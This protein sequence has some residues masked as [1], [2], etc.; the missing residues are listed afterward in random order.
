MLDN[1][2]VYSFNWMRVDESPFQLEKEIL[3]R[4]T[5]I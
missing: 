4:N 1:I 3:K 2:D 5:C